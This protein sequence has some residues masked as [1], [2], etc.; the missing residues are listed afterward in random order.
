MR[1]DLPGAAEAFDEAA[2][3][4]QQTQSTELLGMAQAMQCRAATWLGDHDRARRLGERAVTATS[5]EGSWFEA[6][7]RAVLAQA[8]LIGGDA[9]GVV[10]EILR[11][12][13]GPELP[14]FDPASQCDFLEV[15]TRAAV[16]V[17]RLDDANRFAVQAT[18]TAELLP[19]HAPGGGAALARAQV[20]LSR[21]RW[22]KAA[23]TAREAATE[24]AAIGNRLEHGRA[25]LLAG[26]ALAEGHNRRMA[27]KEL[28]VAEA[29]FAACSAAHFQ[30][31]S[32]AAMRRLGVRVPQPRAHSEPK[33]ASARPPAPAKSEQLAARVGSGQADRRRSHQPTDRSAARGQREDRRES[34]LAHLH[35]AR[36]QLAGR[37]RQRGG[38]SEL[39]PRLT[40]L[41]D[42]RD[43]P[44]S[45]P[46]LLSQS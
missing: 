28:R 22:N 10:D 35:Q 24:Y 11:A 25:L 38:R 40:E 17:G 1:G 4:A 21:G 20:L 5:A 39:L 19:L 32:R 26:T 34:R 9:E 13:G 12:G 46:R 36:G 30:A 15:A 6:V 2:E 16:A 23:A 14:R 27:L 18:T 42:V 43:N 44:D 3:V 31:V 33:R 8:R 45:Q 37:D 41:S 7:A 29:D